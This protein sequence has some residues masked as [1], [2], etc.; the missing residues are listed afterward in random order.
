MPHLGFDVRDYSTGAA[1]LSPELLVL[2]P[3]RDA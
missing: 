2:V 1:L 3:R